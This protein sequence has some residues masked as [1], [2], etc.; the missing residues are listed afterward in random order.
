MLAAACG[1]GGGE[2]TDPELPTAPPETVEMVATGDFDSPMDAVASPDGATFYF[3]AHSTTAEVGNSASIFSVPSAGGEVSKL[4]EGEPLEDPS[5]LLMSCDGSTLFV[6][7]LAYDANDADAELDVGTSALY[8]FDVT[9]NQLAPLAATGV[10]EAA[11]LA[12]GPDCDTLY[13]T[14]FTADGLP[15]LFTVPAAGGSATV[16]KAGE[17]LES[18]SGVYVD[19]DSVAWV[20]DQLPSNPLGGG[21]WAIDVEGITMTVVDGLDISEPAGVSLTAGGG[22][23]V[24]PVVGEDGSG[25]L[26]TVSIATGETTIVES[27]MSEPAGLRTATEAGIFAIA[28]ADG[29]AIYRAQ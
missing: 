17:P 1:G 4:H 15:A 20:M 28:D 26:L 27:S 5:G 25:Q 2:T 13:V 16:V 7:D 24:I 9:S 22:T 29:D 23:A 12:M 19:K 10:A 11:G 8:T 18:P 3:T 21:L 14:G 6:A